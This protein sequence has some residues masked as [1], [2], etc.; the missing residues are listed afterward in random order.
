MYI[1][2]KQNKER[3]QQKETEKRKGKGARQVNN[4]IL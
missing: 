2:N 4:D 1:P 3:R